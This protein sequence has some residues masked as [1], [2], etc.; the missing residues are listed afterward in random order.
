L[1]LAILVWGGISGLFW[2]A[3]PWWLRMLNIFF[4]YFS[5]IRYSSGENSLFSS[6]PHF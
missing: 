3:F 1:I 5:A 2:F 4:R 6:E